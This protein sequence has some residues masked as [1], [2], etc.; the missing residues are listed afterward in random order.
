[1]ATAA[2]AARRDVF[3]V[4]WNL[5]SR[6]A[7]RAICRFALV[8]LLAGWLAGGQTRAA[9]ASGTT[10]E[11]S[12]DTVKKELI[13]VIDAQLA[14]FR[15]DDFSRAYG[16]AAGSIRGMFPPAAFEKMVRAGYPLIAR[17]AR[18]EYGIALDSGDDA[19]IAVRVT[20]ADEK[21]TTAEYLYTL[22][23]EN[24]VWKITGVS[25]IQPGGIEA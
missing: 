9:H 11:G 3:R 23:K 22:S 13:A 20:G 10:M 17:S 21:G 6:H 24:G 19:A 5:H 4:N 1:M 8:C 14:A 2:R 25:A 16:F 15:E 7:A 12:S 18:A